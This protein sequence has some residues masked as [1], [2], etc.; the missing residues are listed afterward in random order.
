MVQCVETLLNQMIQLFIKEID[1]DN[2]DFARR[3]Q[4]VLDPEMAFHK[5]F[6][7]KNIDDSSPVYF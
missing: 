5:G 1:N 7:C 6:E 4:T 3:M 2:E